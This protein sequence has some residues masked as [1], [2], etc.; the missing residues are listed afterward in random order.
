MSTA[1]KIESTDLN[2]ADLLKD[3][4]SVPDFQR[5]YVWKEEH[6]RTLMDDLLTEF[7]DEGKQVPGDP[8]YFI[9][10]I[11]VYPDEQGTFR[12]IDGQQRLTTVYLVL[13]AIRDRL[14]ELQEKPP[15]GLL[16][17]IADT[18]THPITGDDIFRD[19]LTLQYADSEHVLE[20]IAEGQQP[21]DEI[22]R[23]TESVGNI[24]TAYKAIYEA[25][26]V[27]FQNDAGLLKGFY[28]A[29]THRV[30]LIRI[31]TPGITHA[32][33]IFE[34]INDRGVGLNPM[35]LLKNLLFMRTGET[36]Q[37]QL[38]T[39][40][41]SLVDTLERCNE[42]PLRYLRYYILGLHESDTTKP[43]RE[44]EIYEYFA[45]HAGPLG[46]N[47]NPLGFANELV[48]RASDY[49]NFVDKKD[50]HGT[51]NRY[52]SNIAELSGLAR[53]HFI[54]LLAGHH[55]DAD[56]FTELTRHLENL[57][58]TYIVTRE[59]TKN[60]ERTFGRWSK[61]LRTVTTAADLEEFV[62][63]YIRPDLVRRSGTFDFIFSQLSL[64]NIQQYRMRY[65]LAKLT[66]FIQE[67]ALG[68]PMA[69]EIKG[70]LSKAAD[71]EHI[72]PR[73]PR[74]DVRAAFDKPEEYE[75]YSIRLGNLTLLE[76]TINASVSNGSYEEKKSGYLHSSFLLTKSLVQQPHVGQ[77]T[78][79]N[80]AV[81]DLIQF[82]TWDSASI[83]SRQEM[84]GRL[85]RQ[86]WLESS[87]VQVP[88]RPVI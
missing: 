36:D 67:R 1:P 38:K 79:L 52:L 29:F 48:K 59:P 22:P 37:Q 4:Y 34:T 70:Y 13:C 86:V 81:A 9:G 47:H 76:K 30:K 12:L 74:P 2:L 23:T 57:Y 40:W 46:I 62:D 32:L 73:T 28:A 65:I 56:L 50:P 10:S 3:F 45:K 78:K 51:P 58:F 88:S 49:A 26:T 64:K 84:L 83:E 24:L 68:N 21:V 16:K 15:Q 60:F 18:A 72:L 8:E 80:H 66:Q 19:R 11:V 63:R 75:A 54:L 14:K 5:E 71:I 61:D 82:D 53:Q 7:Y 31:K 87:G 25:L 43:L 6:V 27:N 42:K 44:D 33:K 77:N 41:K 20:T 17:Q 55:L 35:D 85:A 39:I 69:A